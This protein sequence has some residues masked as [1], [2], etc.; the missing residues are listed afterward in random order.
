MRKTNKEEAG[1]DEEDQAG[2][3]DA[4]NPEEVDLPTKG[5]RGTGYQDFLKGMIARLE[6]EGTLGRAA[7]YGRKEGTRS[8]K[9]IN[10]DRDKEALYDLDDPFID[11]NDVVMEDNQHSQT[12]P[13]SEQVV[14]EEED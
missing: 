7:E 4:F 6:M 10:V 8:G 3:Y 12:I 11:D 13:L 9:K 5:A 1:E 14:P 2:R